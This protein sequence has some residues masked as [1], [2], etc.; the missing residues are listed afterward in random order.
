M[1][2]GRGRWIAAASIVVQA[3]GLSVTFTRGAWIGAIGALAALT[4]LERRKTWP[5]LAIVLVVAVIGTGVAGSQREVF[6]SKIADVP[7][8]EPNVGRIAIAH[9]AVNIR[10]RTTSS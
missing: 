4:L 8:V 2:A 3:V 9:S 1:S 6:V 7:R 10:L 5:A